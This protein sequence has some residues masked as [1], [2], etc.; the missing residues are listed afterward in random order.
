MIDGKSKPENVFLVAEYGQAT[1]F[2]LAFVTTAV[3]YIVTTCTW[4][5]VVTFGTAEAAPVTS[6]VC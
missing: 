1:E 5:V 4:P 6:A 3:L 2:A